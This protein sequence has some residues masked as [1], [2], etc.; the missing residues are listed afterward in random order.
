MRELSWLLGPAFRSLMLVVAVSPVQGWL[1]RHR[2]PRWTSTI[3]VLLLIYLV[4]VALVGALTT[5]V[6]QLATLLPDCAD[7]T[8]ALLTS[9]TDL[10][11]RYRIGTAQLT[12]PAQQ[13]DVGRVA[14]L[15]TTVLAS[16]GSRRRC[17]RCWPS[18]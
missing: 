8:D 9:V 11:A 16:V 2:V 6:A 3:V 5:S 17:S 1:I 18:R 13:V 14:D 4:L 10:L 15:L 12:E 7:Q